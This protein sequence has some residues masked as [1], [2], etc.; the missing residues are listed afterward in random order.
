MNCQI[1][2][3]DDKKQYIE[4]R[5]WPRVTL[6][7]I[8]PAPRAHDMN[9]HLSRCKDSAKGLMA[10]CHSIRS[11]PQDRVES[12]SHVFLC[13]RE[14]NLLCFYCFAHKRPK[15]SHSLMSFANKTHMAAPPRKKKKTDGQQLSSH[16]PAHA[17]GQN[18]AHVICSLYICGKKKKTLIP[19]ATYAGLLLFQKLQNRSRTLQRRL[20]STQHGAQSQ[21]KGWHQP[22]Y[23]STP[24]RLREGSRIGRLSWS[25]WNFRGLVRSMSSDPNFNIAFKKTT[26]P[27]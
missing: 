12:S 20:A 7:P 6:W 5:F 25:W 11:I 17:S 24:L 9:P 15:M 2:T 14:E 23:C 1:N 13:C 16:V 27:C 19:P 3:S 21:W 22:R 10:F 26:S 8:S 4:E 18:H